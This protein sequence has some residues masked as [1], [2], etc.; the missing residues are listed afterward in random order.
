MAAGKRTLPVWFRRRHRHRHAAAVARCLH[1]HRVRRGLTCGRR[2]SQRRSA[3]ALWPTGRLPPYDQPYALAPAMARNIQ[4]HLATGVLLIPGCV[5][6]PSAT[7][8]DD[9]LSFLT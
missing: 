3:S 2:S 7:A 8:A 1:D 5:I 4:P 6:A 9:P